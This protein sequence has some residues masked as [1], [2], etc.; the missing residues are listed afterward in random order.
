M[1]HSSEKSSTN[2][3]VILLSLT[4]KEDFETFT[5]NSLKNILFCYPPHTNKH[6]QIWR[7]VNLQLKQNGTSNLFNELCRVM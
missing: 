2:V 1:G 6:T 3:V 7:I 4:V 5:K